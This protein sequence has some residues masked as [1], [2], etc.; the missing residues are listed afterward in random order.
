MQAYINYITWPLSTSTSCF[1]FIYQWI[2]WWRMLQLTE[3]V[4]SIQPWR[5]RYRV[6]GVRCHFTHYKNKKSWNTREW[7]RICCAKA[8]LQYCRFK[9]N[10]NKEHYNI[11][12]RQ[13]RGSLAEKLEVLACCL[14]LINKQLT[15]AFPS[16]YI[17]KSNISKQSAVKKCSSATLYVRARK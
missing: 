2:V 9:P 4:F 15:V 8:I 7:W 1:L 11:I 17:P 3:S 13:Q 10:A 6:T 12:E 5:S 14:Q 16:C